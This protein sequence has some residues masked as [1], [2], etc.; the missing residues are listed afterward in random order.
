MSNL[1]VPAR[2]GERF[3]AGCIAGVMDAF[4]GLPLV[5]YEAGD[6]LAGMQGLGF[7]ALG[8]LRVWVKVSE[9][10]GFSVSEATKPGFYHTPGGSKV[11]GFIT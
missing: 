4:P 7:E 11:C 8:P 1:F 3:R 6:D 10:P 2:E 9:K 5:G